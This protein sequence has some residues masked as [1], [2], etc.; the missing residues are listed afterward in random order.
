MYFYGSFELFCLLQGR[1]SKNV[2]GLVILSLNL[3]YLECLTSGL[4][5]SFTKKEKKKKKKKARNTSYLI[6]LVYLA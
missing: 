4:L 1:H 6:F 2:A 5:H 3:Q